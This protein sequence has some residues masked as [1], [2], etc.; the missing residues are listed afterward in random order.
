LIGVNLKRCGRNII[1][2]A[3]GPDTEL[4]LWV[5]MYLGKEGIRRCFSTFWVGDE[6]SPEFLHEVMQLSGIVDVETDGQTA[7]GRWYGFGEIAL[8]FGA[9]ITQA[10]MGGIYQADYLK[11]DG[12]W[13]FKKLAFNRTLHF[14]P[15]EGWVKLERVAAVV[16]YGRRGQ[17]HPGGHQKFWPHRYTVKYCRFFP[18]R[19]GR[20]PPFLCVSLA[21]GPWMS[22]ASLSRRCFREEGSKDICDI[23]TK[24]NFFT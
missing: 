10:F 16:P 7:K 19:A 9:C 6:V 12:K 11:Q 18:A 5:G 2:F 14:R 20:G 8:P 13:K 4:S 15:G 1:Y 22:S 3:D 23:H 17:H 24:T 21:N